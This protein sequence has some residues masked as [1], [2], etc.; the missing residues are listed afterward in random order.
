MAK[1][2]K[3]TLSRNTIRRR[4]N[5][6][7]F[8]MKL[9]SKQMVDMEN[10]SGALATFPTDHGDVRALTYGFDNPE[11]KPLLINIHGSGF[12]MGSAAMDDPFMEQFVEACQVK[13][14]NIDYPLSPDVMFPV[15]L[16]QCYAL[17]RYAKSHA[18][19][20]GIDGDR[21]MLM[22]HSAGGNFCAGIGLLEN[23]TPEL[24]LRGIILDYP[25]TDLS[26]DA[27][28]KP[29][30]KGCL[31]PRM[32]RIFDAA[33]CTEEE[34][35]NPLVSPALVPPDMVD[36]FPPTLVITASLD[37]LAQETERF[38]DTLVSAGVEVEF[39]RFE[40]ATHGFTVMTEKQGKKH[41]DIY[42][43]SREA[44]AL[45]KDFVNRHMWE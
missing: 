25:P 30:P 11:P 36:S 10:A 4:V 14:I 41:P 38:K 42:R 34:R 43:M 29:L 15:A 24:G 5:A 3:K 16:E 8:L 35:F 26:V 17:A 18:E 13:V 27:Y 40:G 44:W 9:A 20:L 45:M 19:E 37:S 2:K 39:K 6:V 32:C 21:I 12:V 22:G 31:P 1:P 7:R 33:Y 28:D 23:S